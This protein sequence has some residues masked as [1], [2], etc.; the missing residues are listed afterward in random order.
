MR[1][2]VLLIPFLLI[3]FGLLSLF[4]KKAL[5]R[6]AQFAPMEPRERPAYWIYQITTLA[7]FLAAIVLPVKAGTPIFYL[8]GVLYLLGLFLCVLSVRDF[9]RPSPCGFCNRGIY[10]ISR[11]PMYVAYFF[12]F[13]GCALLARSCLLLGIVLV[14]QGSAHWIIRAEERWCIARFGEE[15]LRYMQTV[16][17]YL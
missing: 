14:F 10:R 9:A 16:R 17:R 7:I 13:L 3:R 15:Y 1:V 11:N 6:A 12:C 2:I 5:G 4:G 8:G